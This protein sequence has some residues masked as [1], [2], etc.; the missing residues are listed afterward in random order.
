MVEFAGELSSKVI[1]EFMRVHNRSIALFSGILAVV[2]FAV[3][4]VVVITV[5]IAD[6]FAILCIS[7]GVFIGIFCCMVFWSPLF[8]NVSTAERQLLP[9]KVTIS[10]DA[11][12]ME[13]DGNDNYGYASIEMCYVKSVQDMGDWYHIVF[14]APYK[15]S[16]FICQKD[17]LVQGTI[18]QF[19]QIFAGNIVS[20]PSTK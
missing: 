8:D 6:F 20:R 10:Q 5:S 13:L 12:T 7:I 4:L 3:G 17:L 16:Y 1:K 9:T 19:E 15:A 11:I 18:Q 2:V 14:F